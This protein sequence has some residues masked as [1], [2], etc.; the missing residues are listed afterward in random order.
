MDTAPEGTKCILMV[1]KCRFGMAVVAGD[2]YEAGDKLDKYQVVE[3][4]FKQYGKGCKLD[5]HHVLVL[6]T[7]PFF[8]MDKINP[9]LVHIREA[10]NVG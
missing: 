5:L 3:I 2:S 9:S 6:H 7:S 4:P 1:F 10:S 8:H